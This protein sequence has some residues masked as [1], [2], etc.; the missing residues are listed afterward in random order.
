MTPANT[1]ARL[2]ITCPDKPGIVAAVANFLYSHGANITVLDQHSTD[3]EGGLFFMRLEFQTP[4]LDIS[5]RTLES[6]FDE[7]I[8]KRFDMQWSMTYDQDR[9]K[10]AIM[11][12]KND[13]ALLELLWLWRC[14]K[15]HTDISMVISNHPDLKEA[16][17]NFG[18][19]YHYIPIT[20]ETKAE[21]EVKTLELLE[22]KELPGVAALSDR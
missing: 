15:L 16:V 6:S 20:K 8:A 7:V 3:P 11:V 10:T 22:G 21:A 2:L 12:S 9:K 13:H 18:L 14:G 4:H 5:C 1:I 19:P 17:E